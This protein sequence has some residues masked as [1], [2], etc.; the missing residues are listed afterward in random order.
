MRVVIIGAGNVATVLGRLIKNAGH[1][2]VQVISRK[3]DTAQMLADE[4][5]CAATNNFKAIDKTANLFLVAMSDAALNDLKENIN[6]GDKII[7][8]TAGSVNK[9]VLKDISTNYGVLYPLQS[10]RKENAA[11]GL[12]IPLLVDG[13]NGYT[14][15]IVE[16]FAKSISNMVSTAGDEQRQKLHVAAVVTS[17]FP[18]HLYILAADYCS[19]ENI[20]FKMLLPLIEETGSRLHHHTPGEMQTGPAVRKDIATL[21]KQLR[22]LTNYPRLRNIYLKIT[23]SIMNP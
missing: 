13:N 20:D 15:N 22:L 4:L 5:G 9:D 14:V 8:H 12:I 23:D 2:I 17:N 10:L 11:T 3:M 6:V 7:V 19:K 18:N 21:D 1:D 16:S